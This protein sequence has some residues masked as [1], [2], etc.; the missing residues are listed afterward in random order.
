MGQEEGF[1]TAVGEGTA[2]VLLS[3]APDTSSFVVEGQSYDP[4]PA[5]QEPQSQDK[6]TCAVAHTSDGKG[7]KLVF[8][9]KVFGT[10]TIKWNVQSA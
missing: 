2:D 3:F 10:K 5:S 8:T 4:T 6:I 9:W 1:I 7:Y